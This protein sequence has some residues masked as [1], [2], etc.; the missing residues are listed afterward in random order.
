MLKTI[1]ILV[2]S[3]LASF[4]VFA[5]T[6]EE[7]EITVYLIDIEEINSRTQ[8]FVANVFVS[9]QWQDSD[10]AHAG[11]DPISMALDDVW[12]Y[13]VQILNQQRLVKTFPDKARIYPD[14]SV[15]VRQRYWGGFSQPMELANFPFDQQRIQLS[16][17]SSGFGGNNV[18]FVISP[19][20]GLAGHL[21]IPDWRVLDWNFA[22]ENLSIGRSDKNVL[23]VVLS[24]DIKRAISFFT[25]KVIFPLILIVAMSW[26]VFWVGPSLVASKISVGVTAMLTLIAYRFAIGGMVPRLSFL[27]SLDYFVLGSTV[28]VFLT[29]MIVAYTSYLVERDEIG[30]ARAVDR[31]ARWIVPIIFF[32]MTAQTLW[33]HLDLG[34]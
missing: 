13:N 12:N 23:S 27:T 32:A 5:D 24:V 9:L 10:L 30:S 21:K 29:L 17:V 33:L 1:L 16:L 26:L 18:N 25:L 14:G 22:V 28:L 4:K 15:T 31:K 6:P 11:P 8:S 2:L 19:D 3:L 20:S 7:V 34:F